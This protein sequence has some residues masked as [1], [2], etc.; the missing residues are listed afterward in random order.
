VG[1]RIAAAAMGILFLLAVASGSRLAGATP[2]RLGGMLGAR[3]SWHRIGAIDASLNVVLAASSGTSNPRTD[4][5]PRT[6]AGF[7]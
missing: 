3:T 7:A 5:E 2:T 6:V 4:R 1:L